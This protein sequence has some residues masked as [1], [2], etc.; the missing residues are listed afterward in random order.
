MP[1]SY[2]SGRRNHPDLDALPAGVL[3][4]IVVARPGP[5]DARNACFRNEIWLIDVDRGS[6]ATTHPPCLGLCPHRLDPPPEEVGDVVR[7]GHVRDD[8]SR[9]GNET[10]DRRAGLSR[11]V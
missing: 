10:P 9:G 7:V 6:H 8:R 1:T 5:A 4:E 11:R 3:P 2:H